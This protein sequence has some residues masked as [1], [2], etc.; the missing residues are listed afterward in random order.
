MGVEKRESRQG[1][2]PFCLRRRWQRGAILIDVMLALVMGVFIALAACGLMASATGTATATRENDLACNAARQVIE[3]V[4]HFRGAAV[5]D[6]A[7]ADATIFGPVPQLARL[8]AGAVA[9]VR[10]AAYRGTLKQV[11]ATVTWKGARTGGVGL[12]RQRV[13]TAL[14]APRGVTP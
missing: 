3:N 7:Y 12:P 10:V 4:R 1:R 5:A 14:V 8:P 6:N 2:I 9:S 13:L 11:V